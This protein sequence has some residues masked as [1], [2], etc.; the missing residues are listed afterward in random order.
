V[1]PHLVIGLNGDWLNTTIELPDG[2]WRNE[3][4]GDEERGG[5]ICLAARSRP[6]S[7]SACW[8]ERRSL[9]DHIPR[10]DGRG[11]AGQNPDRQ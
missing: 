7:R 9:H 11:D 6:L 3:L 10:L 4:M 1:V 8:Y 2:Q 5:M